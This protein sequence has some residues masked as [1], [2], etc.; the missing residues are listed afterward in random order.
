MNDPTNAE[1]QARWRAKQRKERAA[2][3]AEL[4]ALRNRMVRAGTAARKRKR[5]HKQR[6]R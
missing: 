4:R 2:L 1:R 5:K 6:R 3:E